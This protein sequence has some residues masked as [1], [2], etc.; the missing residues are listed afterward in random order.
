MINIL[1]I[2]NSD[3]A[4]IHKIRLQYAWYVWLFESSYV[5]LVNYETVAYVY[6]MIHICQHFLH[7]ART[8]YQMEH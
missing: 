3:S 2:H 7:Q 8:L 5:I 4:W 6:A 1:A